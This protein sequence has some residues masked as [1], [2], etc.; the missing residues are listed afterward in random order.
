MYTHTH[1]RQKK[2]I[3]LYSFCIENHACQYWWKVKPYIQKYI[4]NLNKFKSHSQTLLCTPQFSIFKICNIHHAK[5]KGK[6]PTKL[7]L[8]RICGLHNLYSG[9]S[10]EL[11]KMDVNMAKCEF[12]EKTK[13]TCRRSSLDAGPLSHSRSLLHKRWHAVHQNLSFPCYRYETSSHRHSL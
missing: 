3:C 1:T 4:Q 2:K 9:K 12:V 6:S 8:D 10:A 5:H 13:H 11:C 7:S